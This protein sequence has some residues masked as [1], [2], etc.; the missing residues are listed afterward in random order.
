MNICNLFL[1]YVFL[2]VLEVSCNVN[3]TCRIN[4]ELCSDD[5]ECCSG[6]C[7]RSLSLKKYCKTS[8]LDLMK[9]F[10]SP[11]SMIHNI[12][13]NIILLLVLPIRLG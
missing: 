3:Q 5:K 4:D 10:I 12:H 11:Q 7:R 1:I 8:I 2:S 6:T 9:H 13:F